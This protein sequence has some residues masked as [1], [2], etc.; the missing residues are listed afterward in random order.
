MG[1]T[2]V[3]AGDHQDEWVGRLVGGPSMQF[4]GRGW[5]LVVAHMRPGRC[6]GKAG[7]IAN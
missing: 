6:D 4:V 1:P 3:A 5:M 7:T 2:K